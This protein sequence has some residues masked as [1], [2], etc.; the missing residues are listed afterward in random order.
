MLSLIKIGKHFLDKIVNG[1][2]F[3]K[4]LLK[5]SL[6]KKLVWII[7]KI[8]HEVVKFDIIFSCPNRTVLRTEEAVYLVSLNNLN[9]CMSFQANGYGKFKCS[10]LLAGSS[11]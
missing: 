11:Q 10:K 1:G 5:T 6:I 8:W 3:L 2:V 9:G 7:V 4:D